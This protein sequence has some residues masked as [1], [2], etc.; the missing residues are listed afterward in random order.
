MS[1]ERVTVATAGV[2]AGFAQGAVLGMSAN[3]KTMA[4]SSRG[5]VGPFR[6]PLSTI[7]LR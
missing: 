2:D 4:G 3:L 7:I 1:V 6:A 5:A